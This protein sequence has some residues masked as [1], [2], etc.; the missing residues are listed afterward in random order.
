MS[1]WAPERP[2]H[3]ACGSPGT[4]PAS[5]LIYNQASRTPDHRRRE[6]GEHAGH[7]RH[8]EDDKDN[9]EEIKAGHTDRAH[10]ILDAAWVSSSPHNNPM[11]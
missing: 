5:F 2:E 9:C 11:S 10:P 7:P 4:G 6:K 1:P 3:K 8:E